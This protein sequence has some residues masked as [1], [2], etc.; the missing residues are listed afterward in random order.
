MSVLG[1]LIA[2]SVALGLVDP[3]AFFWSVRSGQ[4]DDLDGGAQRIL[5]GDEAGDLASQLPGTRTS[6]AAAMSVR[7]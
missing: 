2:G 3:A 5:E 7:A 1:L 4:Y 6:G